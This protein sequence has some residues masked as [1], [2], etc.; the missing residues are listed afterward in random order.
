[1]LILLCFHVKC[2]ISHTVC[3]AQG[4]VTLSTSTKIT[5]KL[6]RSKKLSFATPP[7]Q[8]GAKMSTKLA[9]KKHGGHNKMYPCHFHAF[10]I[11]SQSEFKFF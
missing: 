4:E 7:R 10:K 8:P 3:F 6:L 9:I 11:V 5:I 1:M 2:P